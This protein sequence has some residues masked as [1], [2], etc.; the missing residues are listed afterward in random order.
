MR[1]RGVIDDELLAKAKKAT[2]LTRTK[3]VIELA[4][5]EAIE[6]SERAAKRPE[7]PITP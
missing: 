4:L 3:A 1:L 7:S 6:G 2:G 5:R